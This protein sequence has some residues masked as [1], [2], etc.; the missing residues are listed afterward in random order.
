M[1]K[2]SLIWIVLMGVSVC[3]IQATRSNSTKKVGREKLYQFQCGNMTLRIAK[4]HMQK[5]RNLGNQKLAH[6]WSKVIAGRKSGRK[7]P[8]CARVN[9]YS[10]WRNRN[11]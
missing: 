1:K 3:A 9:Q 10:E 2:I 5:Q 11:K 8:S 7:Y 6:R 4:T